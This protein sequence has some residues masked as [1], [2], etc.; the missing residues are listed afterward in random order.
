V[1]GAEVLRTFRLNVIGETQAAG[2]LRLFP[3]Q[4]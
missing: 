1:Q 4:E 3:G 2:R